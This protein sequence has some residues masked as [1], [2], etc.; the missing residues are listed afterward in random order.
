MKREKNFTYCIKYREKDGK[1]GTENV[2]NRARG[3]AQSWF[4]TED[5]ARKRINN[6]LSFLRGA[7]FVEEVIEWTLSDRNGVI[8]RGC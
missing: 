8:D 2:A 4:S 7:S 3:Y 6:S 1:I 5:A